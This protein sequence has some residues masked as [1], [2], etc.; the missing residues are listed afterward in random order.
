MSLVQHI[1]CR[2]LN[3]R[4]RSKLLTSEWLVSNGL[5]GYSSGTVAGVATRRYHGLLVAAL[6]APLGRRMVASN[7]AEYLQLPDARQV[8]LSGEKYP[9]GEMQLETADY[10]TRFRLEMGL[11][12]WQWEVDGITV[13]KRIVL[14]HKQN[15]VFLLFRMLTGKGPLRLKLV[16]SIHHRSHDDPVNTPLPGTVFLTEI[17]GRYEFSIDKL[18]P[19][20]LSVLR[21]SHTFTV[22]RQVSPEEFYAVEERRGYEHRGARWIPGFFCV[23]LSP[24]Q[25][26]AFVASTEPWEAMTKLNPEDVLQGEIDRRARLLSAVDD[27]VCNGIRAELV[28]AADQ[29]LVTLP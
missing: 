27:T 28:L 16:P 5:G 23:D 12:V 2:E 6:P 19:L 26:T 21:H 9:S 15:T 11:P 13:E 3:L 17:D 29:F 10:L 14:P 20:R 25:P 4:D 7:L 18:P 8:Q 22:K 1:T 24:D